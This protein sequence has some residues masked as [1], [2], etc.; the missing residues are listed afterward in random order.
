M[1]DAIESKPIDPAPKLDTATTEKDKLNVSPTGT[2]IMSQFAL[3][4]SAAIVL[5]A[6]GI[7]SLPIASISILPPI[8]TSVATIVALLG[9]IILSALSPGWRKKFSEDSQ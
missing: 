3:K 2:P 9:G 5:V 6:G 1:S 4:I 8:V 7:A